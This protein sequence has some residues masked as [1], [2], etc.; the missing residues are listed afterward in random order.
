MRTSLFNILTSTSATHNQDHSKPKVSR[1]RE[2]LGYS[3]PGHRKDITSQNWYCEVRIRQTV[4]LKWCLSF[5][6]ATKHGHS[7]LLSIRE[8]PAVY[9]GLSFK[10]VQVFKTLGYSQSSLNI[11]GNQV[12][13]CH[14]EKHQEYLSSSLC[15]K[16]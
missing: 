11:N 14:F 8:G 9:T 1:E 15:S 2:H 10:I 7:D 5:K 12:M 4:S 6:Y 3:F 16:T 13:W